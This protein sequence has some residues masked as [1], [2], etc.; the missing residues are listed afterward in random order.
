MRVAS[1]AHATLEMFVVY[2]HPRDY[3]DHFVVRR[4]IIGAQPGEPLSDDGWLYIADTLEQIRNYI[5]PHCVR[6]ERDPNDEPQIV[7]SWI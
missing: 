4:W 3:P 7:E 6:L 5:P 1:R 2:D